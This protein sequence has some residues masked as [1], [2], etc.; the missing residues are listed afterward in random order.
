MEHISSTYSEQISELIIILCNKPSTMS[1]PT[2]DDIV[3]RIHGRV[4]DQIDKLNWYAHEGTSLIICSYNDSLESEL[5]KELENGRLFRLLAKLGFINERP[6]YDMSASWSETGDR[7]L[8]KLY[9]DYV[10]H[11]VYEDGSPV[12]D[13][14][15]VVESLNKVVTSFLGLTK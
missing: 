13:F 7:Y 11:Q 1:F 4:L 12:L 5:A 10:F 15:H 3:Q 2:I 14:A 9:R 8:L 6:E